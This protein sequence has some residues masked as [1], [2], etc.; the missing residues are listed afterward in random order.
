MAV[1]T[2]VLAVLD[3]LL[4]AQAIA[5]LPPALVG[6]L[7]GLVE[8]LSKQGVGRGT[9]MRRDKATGQRP[10][11]PAGTRQVGAKRATLEHMVP[12]MKRSVRLVTFFSCSSRSALRV[13]SLF[14]FMACGR[15]K[16]NGPVKHGR[17]GG[18][19]RHIC[20]AFSDPAYLVLL[21]QRENA[22]LEWRQRRVKL[23]LFAARRLQQ[24]S[25]L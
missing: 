12:T 21:R 8:A 5:A 23:V 22:R 15:R 1:L 2:R 14:S 20:A 17:A 24:E 13:S 10:T 9:G 3:H 4:A 11:R 6:L 25:R 18:A 7:N 16:V 19:R